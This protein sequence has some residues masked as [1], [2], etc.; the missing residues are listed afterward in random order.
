MDSN[1]SGTY[2]IWICRR[3]LRFVPAGI[4]DGAVE[5]PSATVRA[6]VLVWHGAYPAWSRRQPGLRMEPRS[7]GSTVES[8]GIRVQSPILSGDSRRRDAGSTGTRYVDL[9][10]FGSPTQLG[11]C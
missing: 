8:R 1:G 7:S 11:T 6:V 9:P 10:R 2:G 4:A 3:P 5:S